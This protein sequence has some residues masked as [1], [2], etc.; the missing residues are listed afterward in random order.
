[1]LDVEI[2]DNV[3]VENDPPSGH[4]TTINSKIETMVV[5]NDRQCSLNCYCDRPKLAQ[6]WHPSAKGYD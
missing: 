1:M 2:L 4:F 3:A 5:G 6:A